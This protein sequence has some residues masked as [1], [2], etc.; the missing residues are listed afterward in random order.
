MDAQVTSIND[1][2][3]TLGRGVVFYA[4]KWDPTTPLELQH[5]GDTQGDLVFN[6]NAEVAFMTLP[7]RTG[8]APVAADYTG[9]A[10]TI[11]IPLYLADPAL[12][13][14]VSP[15]NS[16]SAG[17]STRVAAKEWTL[18]IFPEGL[19]RDAAG[20]DATLAYAA[21]VWTVGGQ[22]LTAEQE[23]LLDSA[24]WI[25]RGVFMR[26]PRRFLGGAGDEKRQIETVSLSALVHPDLPEGHKLY[27][28]G[29]PVDA[30]IELDGE[31]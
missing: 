8:P 4:D 13:A 5:L 31:S 1:I 18:A 2:R 23:V 16:G 15:G 9:E 14:V 20:D 28:L 3:R 24:L 29:N 21:G 25:W 6:P 27:T 26:P 30:S 17:R 22:A 19:L 12:M 11:E 10:P 7:E